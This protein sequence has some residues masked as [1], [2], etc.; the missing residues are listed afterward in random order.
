MED[1]FSHIYGENWK[2]FRDY[3]QKIN[4]ALPF[5]YFSRDEVSRDGG[6]HHKPEMAERISKIREITK[7][8]RALI[9]K[10]YDCEYYVQTLALNLLKFHADF[11]DMISDWMCANA[12]GNFER[13]VELYELA[14]NELGKKEA[15]FERYYDHFLYFTEYYWTQNYKSYVQDN[16]IIIR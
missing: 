12:L 6:D 11:C 15:E 8:G 4:D 5:E 10:Y 3:F 13:A 1:Y 9:E 2:E 14:K 16:A 7:E